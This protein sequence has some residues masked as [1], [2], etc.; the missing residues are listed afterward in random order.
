MLGHSTWGIKDIESYKLLR[1]QGEKIETVT[2]FISLAPKSL[3]TMIA[4]TKLKDAS[5]KESYDKPRQHIKKQRHHFAN[6]DLSSRSYVFSSS[7]VQMWKLDHNEGWVPNNWCFWIAVLEKT[8]ESP[9]D[10]KI[11]PVNP[12]GNQPEYSLEGMMMKLNLQYFSHQMQRANS[13]EKTLMLGNIEGKRRR[14][15]HR[16]RWVDSIT[17]STDLNLSKPCKIVK[18]QGTL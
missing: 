6:K 17:D 2:D 11:K 9:L 8:L 10:S 3:R 5:W 1:E 13:L 15:Q 14:G 18:G 12:K 7:H 16:M 4:A